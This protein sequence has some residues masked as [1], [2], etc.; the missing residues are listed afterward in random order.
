M[1]ATLSPASYNYEET[2]STLRYAN[3][4]KSI[5]NKPVINEDPKD[6]MLR[7][8]QNEIER[9]RKEL[10]ARQRGEAP[11]VIKKVVKKVKKTKKKSISG[12]IQEEESESQG[13][14]DEDSEDVVSNS[15]SA[16]DPAIL[17]K[18]Q[19]EVENE[20][21]QLLA[22]KDMVVEEKQRIAEELEK[23]AQDLEKERQE[24]EALA[25]QL[26]AMEGKLIVGGVHIAE[27]IS[28]QERELFLA[29][30]RIQQEQQRR[31]VLEK[32]L[33]SK[34]EAQVQLEENFSSLQE[35][36]DVKTKK[37]EKL[38]SKIQEVKDEINDTK[39]EFRLEKEDLLDTI[40]ELSRELA[41]KTT[42][43][44]NFIPLEEQQ[45]LEKLVV[46][47]EEKEDWY[48]RKSIEHFRQRKIEIPAATPK[49]RRPL[50]QYAKLVQQMGE[51][52][53]RYRL[54]NIV[55]LPVLY[56]N[57]AGTARTHNISKSSTERRS[58]DIST[59]RSIRLRF[60]R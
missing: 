59:A 50:C 4:A 42:I 2:L 29:E 39:D 43:T 20:K 53:P 8:Y 22:S 34:Q 27:K 6:A 9:L 48:L 55:T 12:E 32:R 5:K 47:D 37:L 38:V 45:K 11:K 3:R 44:E 33:E 21:K 56:S 26:A 16:L 13:E 18:L 10:E 15:L 54:E 25:K 41:L 40:R 49:I 19:E 28:E 23:R 52:T 17:S 58:A 30:Q 1:I 24:R 57:E 36:V 60:C 46:F 51:A 7:E 14:E 31:R 35:E